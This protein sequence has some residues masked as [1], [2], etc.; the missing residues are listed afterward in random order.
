M[1][2]KKFRLKKESFKNFNLYKTHRRN[3]FFVVK[4]LASGLPFSRFAAVV[5]AGV[6]KSSVG[7]SKIKRIIFDFIRLNNLCAAPGK[8]VLVITLPPTSQLK[9]TEIEKE[10]RNLFGLNSNENFIQ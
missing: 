4:I 7:R 3:R 2:A 6:F 1:L 10:L 5:G 9:K 8:D